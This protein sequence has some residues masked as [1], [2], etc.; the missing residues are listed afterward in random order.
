[1]SQF[2]KL[3]TSCVEFTQPFKTAIVCFDKIYFSEQKINDIEN[4]SGLDFDKRFFSIDI[5]DETEVSFE[6]YDKEAERTVD[7][8]VYG[9]F[10]EI[11][12]DS[13]GELSK[14]KTL[15]NFPELSYL[16]KDENIHLKYVVWIVR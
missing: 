4:I 14:Y 16:H 3:K 6:I 5:E 13:H 12:G 9:I 8:Y 1:M 7:F 15:T 11:H 10:D 2:F